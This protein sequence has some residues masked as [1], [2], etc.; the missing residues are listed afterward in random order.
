MG[1]KSHR[2]QRREFCWEYVALR[3]CI[4]VLLSFLQFFSV[5]AFVID[6][7]RLKLYLS[8]IASP[9]R[10]CLP[11]SAADCISPAFRHAKQQLFQPFR[12]GQWTRLAAVGLLAGELS[13]GSC[14]YSPSM[15][16]PSGGSGQQ[17]FAPQFPP[18]DPSK[19]GQYLGL[20]LFAV[21]LIMILVLVLMY[22]NSVFRFI[23]FDSVLRKNCA[24]REGWRRWQKAGQ[25][26]F[27]WQL[28]FQIAFGMFFV[29][30]LGIP[31]GIALLLGWIQQPRAH[32]L[33][34]V[35]GGIFLFLLLMCFLVF[36]VVVHVLAKDF[37]VPVMGLEDLDFADGWSRLLAV[38]KP[39]KG[40]YAAYLLLKLGLS[41]CAFV[42]FGIL[43]VIVVVIYLIPV[44]G[45][46][47]AVVL[48]GKQAG[49]TWT[50]STIVLAVAVGLFALALLFYLISLVSV[51][52]TVFFPAYAIYFF[53]SRYPAL[54]A[55]LHPAP[56]LP[57]V[58]A[59]E[60]PPELPP[61]PPAPEPIG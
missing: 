47:A 56:T 59:S 12:L 44:G 10:P 20:I 54:D 29:I 42:L 34:L 27:L 5:A 9:R 1:Y 39:E 23:L 37:L 43:A 60:P 52:A 3:A 55:L 49:L 40:S 6:D 32:M 48:L 14:N 35:L 30:L 13:S 16:R 18:F 58:P 28:V 38:M 2:G 19:L 22:L 41:I 31:V 21:V 33:P 17:S 4:R 26:F 11:I 7:S 15:H 50:A 51:P 46:G 53:A 36:A 57:T 61:L 24:I 8:R 25:R 45:L